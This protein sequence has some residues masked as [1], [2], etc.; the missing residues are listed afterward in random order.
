[1][2]KPARPDTYPRLNLAQPVITAYALDKIKAEPASHYDLQH[3]TP[4]SSPKPKKVGPT[5]YAWSDKP[6]NIEKIRKAAH[7]LNSGYHRTDF[8]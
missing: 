7:T 1:M 3:E 4:E 6:I 2:R 8:E 5:E